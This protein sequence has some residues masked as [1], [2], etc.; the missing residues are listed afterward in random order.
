MSDPFLCR[1]VRREKGFDQA[2]ADI[3]GSVRNADEIL[4][5]IEFVLART[6]LTYSVGSASFEG[7]TVHAIRVGAPPKWPAATVY[8]TSDEQ[9]VTLLSVKRCADDLLEQE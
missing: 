6:P 4:F 3:Y 8:Y 2:A 1:G 9:Y 7:V 5:G